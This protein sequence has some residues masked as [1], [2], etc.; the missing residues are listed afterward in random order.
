VNGKNICRVTAEKVKSIMVNKH[1]GL[2][3]LKNTDTAYL[4]G[5]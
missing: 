1:R 2:D 5:T 3:K 4:F